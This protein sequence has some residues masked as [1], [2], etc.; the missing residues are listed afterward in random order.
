[1]HSP[2]VL[3]AD[4]PTGNIDSINADEVIDL[5]LRINKFGTTVILVSHNREIVN[6]LRKR[7]VTMDNGMIVSDQKK[8]KY[9]L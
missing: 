5:L 3:L 4:E 7:V 8:G 1:V 9:I 2:K 6:K